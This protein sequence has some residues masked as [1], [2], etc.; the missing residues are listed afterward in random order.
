[1]GVTWGWIPWESHRDGREYGTTEVIRVK[2]RMK[3]RVSD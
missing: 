3:N 1:M 2:V